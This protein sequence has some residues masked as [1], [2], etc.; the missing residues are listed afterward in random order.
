[1]ISTVAGNGTCA[2]TGDGGAATAASLCFPSAIR[3]DPAGNLLIAD[4]GNGVIRK[5]SL[6]GFIST[7]AGNGQFA[8]KGDGGVAS[9]ASFVNLTGLAVDSVGNV[10]AADSGAYRVRKITPN[11]TIRTVAGTG[12]AGST[13]DGG[14]ATAAKL[15]AM[16]LLAVDSADNLYIADT[17]NNRVRKVAAGVMSTVAGVQTCCAVTTKAASTFI[18]S[19][20][21]MA[22]DAA[23]NMY[24]TSESANAIWKVAPDN[25]ISIAAGNGEAGFTW[26]DGL[27]GGI[28]STRRRASSQ[29]RRGRYTFADRF[30]NRIRELQPDS[31]TGLTI[32]EREFADGAGGRATGT[33]ADGPDGVPGGASRWRECR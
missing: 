29:T 25:S 22:F 15:S 28:R 1:M 12:A 8:D 18:G 16:Q 2:Y 3:F 13:G 9:A 23:G 14:L 20:Q 5:V 21:G 10:Y 6:S 11:G 4:G 33:A 30:N 19:V 7:F 32:K 26:G 27:A 17:G 31:P 24:V